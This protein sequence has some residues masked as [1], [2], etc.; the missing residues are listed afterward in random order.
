[1]DQVAQ[2]TVIAAIGDRPL[3]RRIRALAEKAPRLNFNAIHLSAIRLSAIRPCTIHVSRYVQSLSANGAVRSLQR[4]QRDQTGFTN[5]EPGNFDEW[6]TTN[7]AI[8]GEQS[9]EQSRRN[10]LGPACE[11]MIRQPMVRRSALGS[12]Y[13]KPS[14]VTATAED[15]LQ[16]PAS[17]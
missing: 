11:P 13:S 2:F 16:H 12:P 14:T 4:P 8:G 10:A 3:E 6:G 7:T 17:R 1:M 5:G 15:G 9:E